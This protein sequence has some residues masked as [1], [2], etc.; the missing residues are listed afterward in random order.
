MVKITSGFSILILQHYALIDNL[1]R[2][3]SKGHIV[4]KIPPYPNSR[5]PDACTSPPQASLELNILEIL[6]RKKIR[7]FSYQYFRTGTNTTTETLITELMIPLGISHQQWYRP[8]DSRW[9]GNDREP[10]QSNSTSFHRH[11]T[12]KEHKQLRRHKDIATQAE[13]QE[14]SS[15]P[16]DVHQN[17][18]NIMNKLSKTKGCWQTNKY[19]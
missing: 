13:I 8:S 17:T 2:W 4:L 7:L 18:L 6:K 19:N 12:W 9:N 1:M 11:H 10:I 14:V 16:A 5:A 15:L 3:N